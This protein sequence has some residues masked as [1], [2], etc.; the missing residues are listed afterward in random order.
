EV[1][2]RLGAVGVLE[3]RV[4]LL[5][6][7]RLAAVRGMQD[8][9]VLTRYPSMLVVDEAD[10]IE[11]VLDSALPLRPAP[12]AVRRLDDLA[13][14]ADDEGAVRGERLHVIEAVGDVDGLVDERDHL[15]FP[16]TA[17]PE[18]E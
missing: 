13:A 10:G 5:L 6:L 15:D 17:E 8:H 16:V 4:R 12:T 1:E 11:G 18:R 9:S 14:V 3:D 2:L 7:P